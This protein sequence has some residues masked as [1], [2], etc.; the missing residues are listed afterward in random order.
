L[1]SGKEPSLWPLALLGILSFAA[2]FTSKRD[3]SGKSVPPPNN[4]ARKDTG[5]TAQSSLAS[6]VIPAKPNQDTLDGNKKRTPLWEKLAVITAIGLL[7]VNFF[8]M[9][10]TQNA[11]DKAEKLTISTGKDSTRC[12]ELLLLPPSRL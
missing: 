2:L 4:A 1:K 12:S 11:V 6:N 10:A 5:I 7:I 8:Q 3:Q 9:R